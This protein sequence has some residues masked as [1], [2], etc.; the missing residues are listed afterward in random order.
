MLALSLG[1][2]LAATA[3]VAGA[4]AATSAAAVADPDALRPAA[5]EGMPAQVGRRAGADA[6]GLG[7]LPHVDGDARVKQAVRR[8]RVN[9]VLLFQGGCIPAIPD[10]TIY[11]GNE[12]A[13][14]SVATMR[15]LQQLEAGGRP[16]RLGFNDPASLDDGTMW[17]TSW[18]IT[19]LTEADVK[20]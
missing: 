8:K 12:C 11:A 5:A 4:S 16:Y 10:M 20:S 6:R 3:P 1:L 14:L 13:E 2:S 17:P 18:A 19:D 7:R 9:V 15:Y